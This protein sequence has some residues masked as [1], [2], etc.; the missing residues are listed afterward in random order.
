MVS[1]L[2]FNEIWIIDHGTTTEQAAGHTGGRYGKG[3]DLLYRWGNPAAY[4]AG[5]AA[6]QRL[7]AQHDATWIPANCPGAGHILVFNNGR[8]R[9]DG[10]YTSVDEIVPPIDDQGGYTRKAGKPFGPDAATWTYTAEPKSSFFAGHISGAQRLPNGNTLIASGEQGRIFEVTAEGK[11]VWDYLNPHAG[12]LGPEMRPPGRG[13]QNRQGRHPHRPPPPRSAGRR[14][15][16]PPMRPPHPGG[17]GGPRRAGGPGPSRR[18][19]LPLPRHTYPPRPPR[20]KTTRQTWLSP[21]P[22]HVTKVTVGRAPPA[23]IPMTLNHP[24]IYV[25]LRRRGRAD[26]ARRKRTPCNAQRRSAY[27]SPVGTTEFSPAIHRRVRLN[28]PVMSGWH[29]LAQRGRGEFTAVVVC[30]TT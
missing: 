10:E 1:V 30:S 12:D 18:G 13:P 17:P 4:G 8:G 5:T 7:F 26:S 25:L 14:G 6:D 24:A 29:G 3:G 2:A 27:T 20:G 19:R 22:Y 23:A 11:T 21:V 16:P 9:P 15:G 28:V